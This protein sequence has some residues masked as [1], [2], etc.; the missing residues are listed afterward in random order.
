[1]VDIVFKMTG[2]HCFHD[3][4]FAKYYWLDCF[5]FKSKNYFYV[6]RVGDPHQ[7]DPV[8]QYP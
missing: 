1:M 4:D 8:P 7:A 6:G 5:A 3:A 2:C